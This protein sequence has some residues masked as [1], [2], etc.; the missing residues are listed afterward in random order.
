MPDVA[1][2][3]P[4]MHKRVHED[5]MELV[6]TGIYLRE[7]L[8]YVV[9]RCGNEGPIDYQPGYLRWSIRDRRAERRT[10]MQDL[11]ILPL[12]VEVPERISGDSSRMITAVFAPF[13]LPRDKELVVRMAERN[14]ARGLQLS[15][16]HKEILQARR[17]YE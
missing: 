13:A 8:L 1:R 3:V 9:L 2:F 17:S 7:G 6:L 4:F 14:G 15:I 12:R 5:K 11:E 16:H 10:A